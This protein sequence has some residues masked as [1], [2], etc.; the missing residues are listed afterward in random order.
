MY[1]A[2][3]IEV[4]PDVA[5][6]LCLL[7]ALLLLARGVERERMGASAAGAA[8]LALGML[9]TPKIVYA[10]AGAI[11][12]ALLAHWDG[13]SMGERAH[14]GSRARSAADGRRDALGHGFVMG[15]GGGGV[16]IAAL[17]LL[18]WS[19]SLAG[20]FRDFVGANLEISVGEVSGFLALYGAE[21][22][23]DN[24]PSTFL[25]L[26]GMGILYRK[27]SALPPGLPD[28]LLASFGFAV[29]GL[30]HLQAP[31]RQYYM[32]FLPQLCIAAAIALLAIHGAL[33]ERIRLRGPAL[34]ALL[35][36]VL[37]AAALAPAIGKSLGQY[38][39]QA[40]QRR[41]LAK[42]LEL[43]RPGDRVF[44]CWN[45]AYLS[46]L[47]AFYY[48][49]LNYDIQPIVPPA[50]LRDE[51]PRRLLAPDARLVIW[52]SH[53]AALPASVHNVVA[54]HYRE[55]ASDPLLRVRRD[56][57]P[58]TDGFRRRSE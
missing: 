16:A 49:Y 35:L 43:T 57:E 40:Q 1:L 33:R 15:L 13:P 58:G 52:D 55:V 53:C 48:F 23:V 18:Y 25:G 14:E 20:F 17:A 26:A 19:G 34:S 7:A 9:F 31:L 4:R 6:T 56:D 5:A 39:T 44:D 50:R 27:R 38:G 24:G 47:P 11:V 21:L 10:S 28:V 42:V 36:A 29:A 2:K 32:S 22:L 37:L 46:R 41:R 12:G 30:F 45:G 8:L 54:R 51:L 3:T